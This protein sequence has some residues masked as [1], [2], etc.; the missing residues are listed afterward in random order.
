MLEEGVTVDGAGD[1]EKWCW[2]H[3][4]GQSMENMK[5]MFRNLFSY[6]LEALLRTRL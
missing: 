5:V 6:R 4:L 2:R 3:K 1:H